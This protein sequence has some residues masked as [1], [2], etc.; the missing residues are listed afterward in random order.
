VTRPPRSHPV[1]RRGRLSD[2]AVLTA[3]E[4]EL[5]AARIFAGH[6]MS[7]ASFR[8]CLTSPGS[9]LIVAETG[10]QLVGYVLVFYRCNSRR[11]RLYSIGVAASF[12]RRG[13]ARTLL[14]AAEA[15][16][17]ARRRNVVR[18]E[19][20]EDDP[21]AVTFYHASGYRLFGRHRGYYDGG[22]DALRFEKL[23]KRRGNFTEAGASP[24][25]QT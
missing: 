3:L 12:R 4:T 20:R 22:I 21:A 5:F 7:R 19:V 23:L 2:L 9:T 8:R 10:G 18:L 14:K 25:N 17:A 16:A 11:A 15:A 24:L 1:I 6:V 13:L